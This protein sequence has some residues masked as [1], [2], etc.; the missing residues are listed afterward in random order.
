MARSSDEQ[1]IRDF[2]VAKLRQ[3]MPS[4][5]IVHELNVSGQGS[6][7]LDAGG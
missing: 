6:N 4:A 3:L 5:R 1:E 7:R 2:V